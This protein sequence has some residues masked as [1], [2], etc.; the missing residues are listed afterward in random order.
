ERLE[1]ESR[2]A[3]S[4]VDPLDPS[5][6]DQ[7]VPQSRRDRLIAELRRIPQDV[8]YV[9]ERI[10]ALETERA[11]CEELSSQLAETYARTKD[12]RTGTTLSETKQRI[13]KLNGDIQ[14]YKDE[15]E[16]AFPAKERKLFGDIA[17][18]PMVSRGGDVS[19]MTR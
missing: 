6:L 16:R 1:R 15:V 9:Q 11:Q 19:V 13:Q 4:D 17:N 12:E 14:D 2:D 5:A 7:A 10:K 3:F 8:R 18:E